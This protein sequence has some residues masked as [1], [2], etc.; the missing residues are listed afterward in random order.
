MKV[1]KENKVKLCSWL[2]TYGMY[3]TTTK[4]SDKIKFEKFLK[5]VSKKTTLQEKLETTLK[6]VYNN[7]RRMPLHFMKMEGILYDFDDMGDLVI[8][9]NAANEVITSYPLVKYASMIE[10]T[11]YLER[12]NH[13][14]NIKPGIMSILFY[15]SADLKTRSPGIP[16]VCREM[17]E[18]FHMSESGIVCSAC[19]KPIASK[20]ALDHTIPWIK[21]RS[22]DIWNLHPTH[23]SCNGSKNDN[24]PHDEQIRIVQSRNERMLQYFN[25]QGYQGSEQKKYVNLLRISLEENELWNKYVRMC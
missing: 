7:M 15:I 11:K 21:I 13:S 24:P 4:S 10:L 19:H 23:S 22:H 2:T 12:I 8:S 6:K 16:L 3:S 14:K 18:N 20:Y 1:T 25:T 17:I 5:K 9:K